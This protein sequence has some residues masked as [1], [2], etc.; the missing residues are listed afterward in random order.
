MVIFE[1]GI[2]VDYRSAGVPLFTLS[3]F[4]GFF[5]SAALHVGVCLGIENR[6]NLC[7]NSN[8]SSALPILGLDAVL[9]ILLILNCRMIFLRISSRAFTVKVWHKTKIH[10]FWLLN[11]Y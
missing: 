3:L 10:F 11:Y 4:V 9:L 7:L 8:Y 6:S 2:F 5:I 1:C